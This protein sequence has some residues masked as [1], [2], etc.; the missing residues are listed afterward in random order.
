MN[1]LK[2]K[3][4]KLSCKSIKKV[5]HNLYY[6]TNNT[7]SGGEVAI[8]LIVASGLILV[9]VAG[10]MMTQYMRTQI[11]TPE[12]EIQKDFTFTVPNYNN[13][14]GEHTVDFTATSGEDAF[15]SDPVTVIVT[16]ANIAPAVFAGDD[17]T[18]R[19]PLEATLAG[20]MEDDGLPMVPGETTVEWSMQSGP[21]ITTFE[22]TTTLETIVSFSAPGAYVLRLTADDGKA[23]SFDDIS[24][25]AEPAPP[26]P[27]LSLIADKSLLAINDTFV[28]NVRVIDA[29]PFANWAQYLEFD[30]TKLELIDQQTGDFS[31]FIADT[32]GLTTINSSSQVRAGGFSLTNSNGGTGNLG[33]FTFRAI[34]E[35]QTTISTANKSSGNLFG[36]A[37]SETDGYELLPNI[38]IDNVS[39]NILSANTAPVINIGE[40]MEIQLPVDNVDIVA[41]VSDDGLPQ[42]SSITVLWNKVSG[43]GDVTFNPTDNAN[44]TATFSTVGEYVLRATANDGELSTS[45]DV[46]IVVLAANRAPIAINDSY[47]VMQD[48]SLS[49]NT[50]GVLTNDTDADDDTLT[51]V[52]VVQPQDGTLDLKQDGSFSYQ[53]RDG[54][55][56]TDQAQYKAWDNN[57]KSEYAVIEFVVEQHNESPIVSAG[58]DQ[59]VNF[60][61]TVILNGSA[62]DDGLPEP[63]GSLSILWSEVTGP[64]DVTFDNINIAST[65]ATFSAAGV[66]TLRL[67]ASDGEIVVSDDVIITIN[68]IPVA[69]ADTYDI[70]QGEELIIDAI[71]ILENDTDADSDL[72]EAQLVSS[73]READGSTLSLNANGSFSYTS[74]ASLRGVDSFT[75]KASDGKSL[76]EET[77]V[78][79]NVNVLN[80]APQVNAGDDQVINLPNS[81]TLAGSVSDDGEPIEGTLQM[82][83]TKVSGSGQVVFGSSSSA[84]TS[85]EF[86]EAG[87]YTLRL[88]AN[89]GELTAYD[90]VRII[91]N[92]IPVAIGESYNV[93]RGQLLAIRNPGVLTNDTDANDDVLEAE[94]VD[95]AQL[96]TLILKRDGSFS[97]IYEPN[98]DACYFENGQL[99]T[100]TTCDNPNCNIGPCKQSAPWYDSF[101]YFATD[102][103][104][105]SETVTVNITIEVSNTAPV[106]DAGPDQ[107]IA[108]TDEVSLSGTATDD[109]LP[110][111]PGSVFTQ[112]IMV[113]GP[114]VVT[115]DN[116]TAANTTAQFTQPGNYILRL[117]ASD[118]EFFAADELTVEVNSAPLV[119]AGEDATVLLNEE[120]ELAGTIEDDGIPEDPGETVVQWSQVSGPAQANISDVLSASTTALFS[121]PGE[122]V[123][124]LT[125]DDDHLNAFDEITFNVVT[126]YAEIIIPGQTRYNVRPGDTIEIP[127]EVKTNII[128]VGRLL[129]TMTKDIFISVIE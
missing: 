108:I 33:L 61:D 113:S 13:L 62:T 112:W 86:S 118:D 46:T 71:G 35:G 97:Y 51:V 87:L 127:F 120:V 117:S 121:T 6:R 53:P 89:D 105:Q 85:V 19:M 29:D 58:T 38:V 101:T 12:N 14:I 129:F 76:S 100:S 122:Y 106:V 4:T 64:G 37:I 36:N 93:Q 27:D 114:G 5:I 73:V 111:P 103:K 15:T 52:D 60:P 2:N 123:L 56:G 69:L 30:N 102:G 83:W 24:I 72:L 84:V 23:S 8:G 82:L 80:T 25:T 94:L 99:T 32:R 67:T 91:V 125:A 17:L 77:T 66:Y 18:V 96:G 116:A 98:D 49:V 107:I 7:S 78:T 50:P 44:T 119:E 65:N 41:T 16:A 110:I 95:N 74:G 10:G 39:V 115:F 79:I 40:D 55:Y 75:Y 68:T 11:I 26:A 81:T 109:G 47:P 59:D 92:T 90:E 128:S 34:G 28:V 42:P 70:L 48:E 22:D 9:L 20:T 45:D 43:I 1:L 104:G 124:R 88:M 63:P 57:S 54:F 3:F 31:T 126:K 21:G